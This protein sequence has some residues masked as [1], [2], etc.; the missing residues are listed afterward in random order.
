MEQ[1]AAVPVIQSEAGEA[2]GE[3]SIEFNAL[4]SVWLQCAVSHTGS[5]Q[6]SAIMLKEDEDDDDDV[7]FVEIAS[8][9]RRAR[10]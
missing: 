8:R 5:V 2:H 6:A 1:A 7:G 4:N 9:I 3:S 10:Q